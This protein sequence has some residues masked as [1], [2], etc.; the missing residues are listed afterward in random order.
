MEE[1]R[2]ASLS[3]G[4]RNNLAI[5]IEPDLPLVM[6]DRLRIVQ[7]LGNPLSNAARDSPQASVIR[8]S[9][10]REGIHVAVSVADE[11]RGVEAERLPHL[12]R[13]F[14]RIDG[15]DRG[16]GVPGSGLG[17]AICKGIVEAHGGRIW[18]ESEGPGMGARFTFTLPAV[19]KAVRGTASGPPSLS[20]RTSRRSVGE[21]VRVLAVDDDPQALRY[22]RDAL[23]KAG[24]T[25]VVTGDPEEERPDLVLLEAG[26]SHRQQFHPGAPLN[27][28]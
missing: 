2:N 28:G 19:E 22:V 5:D 12:F 27:L 18:A 21:R 24:Y 7:V 26:Q 10:V 1:A 17:L 25:P 3:G 9:A 11:G 16:S 8:M 13:K 4:D 14:T 23:S 6:A 15:D 20:T